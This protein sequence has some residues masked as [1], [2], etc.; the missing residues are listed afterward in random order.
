MAA[1]PPTRVGGGQA[2]SKDRLCRTCGK[3]MSYDDGS[4]YHVCCHP[5]D[6]RL[7]R[8]W[9]EVYARRD[10]PTKGGHHERAG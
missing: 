5:E 2:M 8:H 3:V 1:A 7:L 6:Q 4:G 9:A 10:R